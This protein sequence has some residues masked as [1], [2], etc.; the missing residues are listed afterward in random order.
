MKIDRDEK[1]IIL[2]PTH[3]NYIDVVRNFLELKEKNWEN[4]PYEIVI[5]IFGENKTID[6]YNCIYNG[7]DSSLIECIRNARNQYDSEYY[8]CFLGDAFINKK[9]NQS[10]IDNILKAIIENKFRYCSLFYTK[11]Y[12]KMKSFN[13]NLRFIHSKDRYSHNFVAYIASANY[14]DEDICSCQTDVDYELKYLGNKDDFYYNDHVIVKS[15]IL[16]IVAGIRKGKWKVIPLQKLKKDNPE[17][18]FAYREKENLKETAY[19]IFSKI[20]PYLPDNIRLFIKKMK[21]IEKKQV[22]KW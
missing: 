13:N 7:K 4:C 20:S 12:K 21:C 17:V 5:S 11:N 16:N 18:N 3:S 15:N 19:G 1:C 6:G 2:M 10:I 9:V 8:M 22:S 14:V